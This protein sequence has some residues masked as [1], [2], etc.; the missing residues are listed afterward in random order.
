MLTYIEMSVPEDNVYILFLLQ[1]L[2]N[3]LMTKLTS[4]IKNPFFF[5]F[6]FFFAFFIDCLR[7][8]EGKIH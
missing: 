7:C 2:N 4:V 3:H 1:E 5:P 8:A 6:L